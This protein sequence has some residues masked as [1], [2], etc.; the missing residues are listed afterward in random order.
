MERRYG[1]G[2][3]RLT[4]SNVTG[5]ESGRRGEEGEKEE[6]PEMMKMALVVNR[7]AGE[8]WRGGRQEGRAGHLEEKEAVEPLLRTGACRGTMSLLNACPNS[9]GRLVGRNVCSLS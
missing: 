9:V 7:A 2:E 5:N 3:K 8:Q 4:G 1:E 6:I